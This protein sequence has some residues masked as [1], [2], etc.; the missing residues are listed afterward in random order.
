MGH[1]RRRTCQV[2]ALRKFC[3]II[4]LIFI[5][6]MENFIDSTWGGF[7]AKRER[8]RHANRLMI[9]G[10]SCSNF[11]R[12]RVWYGRNWYFVTDND[13]NTVWKIVGQ[14]ENKRN[15]PTVWMIAGSLGR[16]KLRVY[17]VRKKL[18]ENEEEEKKQR[19]LRSFLIMTIV[20][21][22]VPVDN[23]RH[24]FVCLFVC[25]FLRPSLK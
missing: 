2:R 9:S 10:R 14:K 19:M 25:F 12:R 15:T 1:L 6:N 13:V 11:E 16:W 3:I 18:R 7:V 24:S 20:P 8:G 5:Y 23:G 17:K 4:M 21:Q 22:C